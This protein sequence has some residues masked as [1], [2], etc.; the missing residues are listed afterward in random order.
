MIIA[1]VNVA[2]TEDIDAVRA[3]AAESLAMYD[4]IE[5]YQKVL[6]R[7]GVSSSVELAAIGTAE[8]VTRRLKTYF[9]AGAT[10]LVL[11][12][13]QTG[14]DDLKRVWDVAAAVG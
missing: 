6:A 5:S 13:L 4:S 12:P 2:V 14:V 11:L 9:D 1:I 10:D 7:E 3:A 8:E